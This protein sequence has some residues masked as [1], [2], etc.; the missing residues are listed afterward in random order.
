M[1]ACSFDMTVSNVFGL[2]CAFGSTLIFVSQNIFFKK[3]MPTNSESTASGPK[4]DKINLLYFSSGMAFILMIPIWVYSDSTRIVNHL[5]SPV[6]KR[7][8]PSLPL[9]FL[10]N[11]TVH[12]A[13]NLLA[14]AI[15]SST[16]PV[17]YSIASLVKRIAV[18]CLAIVWFKQAVHPVQAFGI[19][20]SAVGLWMYNNA[21]RDVEKGERKMRQVEAV[22][23][24]LLPTSI[25][26]QR[27]LDG[28]DT[29]KLFRTAPSKD[30]HSSP[31]PLY[32]PE[33]PPTSKSSALRTGVYINSS[34]KTQASPSE[35]PYPSPPASESSSSPSSPPSNPL[36]A[37]PITTRLRR[38]S[39][40]AREGKFHLPP[41]ATRLTSRAATIPEASA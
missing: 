36:P 34:S 35:G 20:L 37:P 33:F 4:L 28:S 23:E 1:L 32:I 30:I 16:S 3:I 5:L 18:I 9:Y 14:F 22:R 6:G 26:E 25:A 12:F 11:G 8:G 13:Q 40:E 10:L 39:V 27:L 38:A 31:K 17:T 41:S 24:G 29:P 21:K 2:I 7:S 15:L 19:A